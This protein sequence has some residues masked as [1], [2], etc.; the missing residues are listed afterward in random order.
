[1]KLLR[2]EELLCAFRWSEPGSTSA[3]DAKR[4][5]HLFGFHRCM[6]KKRT[7]EDSLHLDG[8]FLLVLLRPNGLCDVIPVGEVEL[9]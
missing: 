9:G 3:L 5:L 7:V 6:T 4:A 8:I 1:M 2:D